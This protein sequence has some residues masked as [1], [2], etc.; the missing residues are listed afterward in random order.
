MCSL[1][2]VLL[3]LA[4]TMQRTSSFFSAELA[5]IG[6]HGF[7]SS[8]SPVLREAVDSLV[9]LL[10]FVIH[11]QQRWRDWNIVVDLLHAHLQKVV[12]GIADLGLPDTS[13]ACHDP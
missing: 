11:L 1:N 7:S 3:H 8:L 10:K 13:C 6:E 2:L 12:Q 9:V 4:E 5:R